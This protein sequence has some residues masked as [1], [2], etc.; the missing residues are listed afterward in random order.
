M[1]EYVQ[2]EVRGG[3][4][5]R[6]QPRSVVVP[7]GEQGSGTSKDPFVLPLRET[8]NRSQCYHCIEDCCDC[9]WMVRRLGECYASLPVTRQ[10]MPSRK[11]ELCAKSILP[12]FVSRLVRIAKIA[13]QDTFYDL[14]C[15]NG[16]V[17][18]QVALMTGARCVG[19]EVNERNATVAREA[20]RR[21]RPAVES[22]RGG[23]VEVEIICG[24]FCALMRDEAFFAASPVVWAANL[25][26]PSSVNH[27]LSERFRSLP[28]GSRVL[29]LADL[30]P[31][32]RSV[33]ALR[34]PDAFEKFA[35]TDFRWQAKSVEWCDLEG[36][37]FMYAKRT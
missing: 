28:K 10:V 24:D 31:H 16:S 36:P 20:W 32:G 21:L 4:A 8:P 23:A 30:Y 34:D 19:V 9:Q 37:F 26:M 5:S 7:C 17:L 25:L 2:R 29:C 22:R 33:A 12:P 14:G 35:M 6:K 27:Y 13:P 1:L 18:F 11:R 15:G 3:R